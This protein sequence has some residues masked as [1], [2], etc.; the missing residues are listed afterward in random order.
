MTEVIPVL[1]SIY[2]LE[3]TTTSRP[4]SIPDSTQFHHRQPGRRVPVLLNRLRQSVE[5]DRFVGFNH[6]DIDDPVVGNDFFELV[7]LRRPRQRGHHGRVGH[8]F[9]R[10]VVVNDCLGPRFHT[11]LGEPVARVR[12]APRSISDT[13]ATGAIGCRGVASAIPVPVRTSRSSGGNH[14]SSPRKSLAVVTW[15]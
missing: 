11:R 14:G 4:Q 15:S 3:S 1:P 12:V 5:E 8:Q 2:S 13:S 7:G 6:A 9:L 10:P